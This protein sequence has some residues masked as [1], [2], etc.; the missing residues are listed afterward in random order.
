M[1][2]PGE[3]VTAH[4]IRLIREEER[5]RCARLIELIGADW[6]ESGASQKWFAAEYLVRQLREL[7]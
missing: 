2:R 5:E 4:A 3:T 1:L 6:K 7:E